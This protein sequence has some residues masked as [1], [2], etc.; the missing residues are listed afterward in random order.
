MTTLRS[1]EEM[2]ARRPACL[3]V[4]HGDD[5]DTACAHA[6]ELAEQNGRIFV[7]P[8]DDPAVKGLLGL[9]G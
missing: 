4:I 6:L 2:G 1:M 5:F 3:V 9:L 7:H 8:Y